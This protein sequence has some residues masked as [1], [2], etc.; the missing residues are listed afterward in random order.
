MGNVRAE[1]F[2]QPLVI[3]GTFRLL[4]Y[5][6][7]R[8]WASADVEAAVSLAGLRAANWRAISWMDFLQ[9]AFF[10]F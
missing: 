10:F 7:L 6:Q 9:D 2:S 5:S 3:F 1:T 8:L 4:Q